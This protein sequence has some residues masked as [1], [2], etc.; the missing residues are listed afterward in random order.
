[1]SIVAADFRK[2]GKTD[3][4]VG[5]FGGRG[6][7]VLLGDGNDNFERPVVYPITFAT[8]VAAAD[9]NGDGVLDLVAASVSENLS[10][11]NVGV[12]L[13]NGDGTFQDAVLFPAGD[14]PNA[15]AIA[16]FNR[17]HM[18]DVTVPDLF[19]NEE[20]VLLN[21]GVVSF[22][23]STEIHVPPRPPQSV[24][25]TNTGKTPLT[26]SSIS[27]TR[28]F[29]LQDT[30]GSSVAPGASCSI[31][32]AFDVDASPQKGTVRIV[33]SASAKAQVIVLKSTSGSAAELPTPEAPHRSAGHTP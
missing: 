12:F 1:M 33:D 22:S 15:L 18:P 10:S 11:G 16:D 3:L 26:I 7:A 5:E 30:C 27:V 20:Q 9:L 14:W 8:K 23:P 4:A 32:I 21:T 24:T 31:R 19:G 2:N 17:D 29:H 28:Y 13:G 25:L 6:V